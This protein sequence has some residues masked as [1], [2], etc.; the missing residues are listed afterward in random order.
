[1]PETEETAAPRRG[2]SR[3]ALVGGGIGIA[4]VG[5]LAGF[6]IAQ[7]D[8][9][10]LAIQQPLTPRDLLGS[11][12]N[13]HFVRRATFGPTAP[14]I[15]DVA[16]TGIAAWIEREAATPADQIDP[17]GASITTV[18]PRLAASPADIAA[19]K[20]GKQVLDEL[21]QATTARAIWSPRQLHEVMTMFWQNHFNVYLRDGRAYPYRADYD[22]TIRAASLTSFAQ[23]LQATLTHPAMLVYLNAN[24][25]TK[26][27]PN[28]NLGRELLEL[29]TLGVGNYTEDDVK[30][31]AFMLTGMT[32][33]NNAF[34]YNP[35]TRYTGPL[36][37][38]DYTDAN[39]NAAAGMDAIAAYLNHLA[40]H[41]ATATHIATKLATR[42]V[43][44]QPSQAL[45]D[46]L[47][48]TYLAND[49]Q[50]VPVLTQLFTSDEFTK[51]IGQKARTPFEDAVATVRAL[52]HTPPT[53]TA[54][55]KELTKLVNTVQH[56]PY[57][58]AAPDGYPLTAD[59]WLTPSS[60][61]A[62]M[63]THF[64]LATGVLMADQFAGFA[65]M[66]ANSSATWA[67]VISALGSQLTFTKIAQPHQQALLDVLGAKATDQPTQADLASLGANIAPAILS[68]PYHWSY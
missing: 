5:A 31:S 46:S 12:P 1:M 56:V 17:L 65:P 14:V 15:S 9:R 48:S 37:I 6:G 36:T 2:L 7:I 20:S 29:H 57:G 26:T 28:E 11:D 22:R 45:I 66:V 53:T 54:Q 3:R 38:V 13:T 44:D 35:K 50:I 51:S 18:L 24:Q 40:R 10:A 30:A 47:A 61:L 43:S 67:D 16:A 64:D 32:V 21:A 68:S 25:S 19:D 42:F 41:K 55:F 49:T 23:L 33:K 4:A 60:A 59:I 52:G 34:F 27:N 8:P 39:A 63:N 62:R 58:H